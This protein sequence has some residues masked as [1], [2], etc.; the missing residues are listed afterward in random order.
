[1][2]CSPRLPLLHVYFHH[3]LPHSGWRSPRYVA[4]QL[5]YSFG[6][7]ASSACAKF[8][9]E[10]V[11]AWD[12]TAGQTE[13]WHSQRGMR[14][15]TH[16][17]VTAA[18]RTVGLLEQRRPR[19]CRVCMCMRQMPLCFHPVI[20]YKLPPASE[21][22]SETVVFPGLVGGKRR[23]ENIIAELRGAGITVDVRQSRPMHDSICSGTTLSI[24]LVFTLVFTL[25]SSMPT[26]PVMLCCARRPVR[27]WRETALCVR[28][29]ACTTSWTLVAT[30]WC[31]TSTHTMTAACRSWRCDSAVMYQLRASDARL[32]QSVTLWCVADATLNAV[33]RQQRVHRV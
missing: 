15:V 7:I 2:W 26:S 20:E 12:Y 24:T 27:T 25:M 33:H 13:F 4:Y 3:E 17:S 32:L 19:H 21:P 18:T 8:M 5:E 16:V 10:A 11:V 22:Q 14:N 28:C 23:R 9:S 1:M 30:R 6:K 31:S 29:T